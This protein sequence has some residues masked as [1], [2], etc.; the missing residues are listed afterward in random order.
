MKI[1]SCN[2]Q[3]IDDEPN[4]RELD[5]QQIRD[6]YIAL[7]ENEF[8]FT[9][10]GTKCTPDVVWDV[11]GMSSINTQT[12]NATCQ[13]LDNVATGEAVRYQLNRGLLAGTDIEETEDRM[14]DLLN[15]Q[16]PNRL[17][18][19]GKTCACDLTLL[20][21]HGA[22][23]NNDNEVRRGKAE[24]GTTHFHVYASIS[25]L[26]KNQRII[27]AVAFWKNDESLEALLSRLLERL[28]NH[29]ISLKR[30]LV[31]REFASVD[32][33][34][35]LDASPWQSIMPVPAR[36][37]FLKDLRSSAKRSDSLPYTMTSS[38]SGK[39]TF[40]LHVVC[41][42]ANGRRGKKGMDRYLFAV[43]GRKWK[44][45]PSNLAE[46]Y[47]RRFGIEADYR[48]MNSVRARTSSRDPK[49][50]LLLVTAAFVLINL[51]ITIRWRK[52]A[53]PRRGGRLIDPS[54]LPLDFFC[55]LFRDAIRKKRGFVQVIRMPQ[56]AVF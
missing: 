28:D 55:N 22:P 33:I 3:A 10:S 16:I 7:M 56:H 18:K 41:Q 21:Y 43:L 8:D 26:Q 25:I 30:L 49:Y 14:N 27:A 51:W 11:I 2:Q 45:A 34:R 47:R 38:D 15:D 52:L 12:I 24:S 1:K 32:I 53:E 40:E 42:Y 29:G 48:M 44:G 54:V 37:D 4:V 46:T 35:Y 39:A 31:D 6:E 13:Q 50:R 36:S 23:K 17:R 19:K 20:P 9:T 5:Y